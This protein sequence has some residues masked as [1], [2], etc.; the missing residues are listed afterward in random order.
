MLE[1]KGITLR[2][3]RAEVLRGVD[4]FARA[5]DVT[6]IAGPNGSGKTSLMRVLTGETPLPGRA[7]LNGL[8]VARTAPG[9]L[10][11]LRA[12]LPQAVQPPGTG[13]APGDL[14]AAK[15]AVRR[16]RRGQ[17]EVSG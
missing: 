11:G 7:W 8:D 14:A 16:Y 2:L 12:V 3:G 6:A 13:E 10:A 9:R 15:R 1:A 5:G 4:F 17:G